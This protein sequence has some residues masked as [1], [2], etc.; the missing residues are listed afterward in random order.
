MQRHIRK[1]AALV[2]VLLSSTL[3]NGTRAFAHGDQPHLPFAPAMNPPAVSPPPETPAPDGTGPANAGPLPTSNPPRSIG[4]QPESITGAC[5]G[6]PTIDTVLLDEC[7]QH[8][9]TL[10]GNS[11]RVTVWYTKNVITATR[12]IDGTPTQ[13]FHWITSDNQAV[14]VGQWAEESWRRYFADSGHE[15]YIDGCSNN[16]NIQLEDGVGWSGIAYWA[17][18]GSCWIGIDAPM[19]RGGGGSGVVFHEMQHYLQY[20]YNAGCYGFLKPN[21]GG[22]SEFVEGYADLGEDS[23]NSTVDATGYAGGGYDPSTSFYD[24]DYNDRFNKYF[25]EQLGTIATPADPWHHM[26]ALYKHYERCDDQDTLYVLDSLVPSLSSG[27]LTEKQ[28]FLNFFAANWAKDW[29]NQAAQPELTY[30]D[31]DTGAYQQPPLTQDISMAGGSQSFPDTT[32]D[33]WAAKYYQ[34]TPQTGCSYLQM[35]VDGAP[36][37]DLG[38]NFMAAKTTAPTNVLRSAKIGEDFVRTFAAA[39]V[40][41]RMVAAVNSFNNNY[42]YTTRFTCVSPSINILEPRQVKFATVG[43]PESPIAFLSRW[44]VTDGTSTVRGLQ[45]SQF[46]FMAGGK[47]LNIVTGTF[48]EVGNQYWA[49]MVPPTQ[50][51]GTTFVDYTAC[52]DTLCDTEPS[53]LLYVNPGNTDIA[54]TFDASGSMLTE[55]TIGEGARITNAKK[56]GAVVADLLRPG[57]RI[58]VTDFSA[59]DNPV[60]CGASAAGNCALDL[61]TLLTRRDVT[62]ATV[63]AR[64]TETRNAINNYSARAWTPVSEGLADAKNKLLAVPSNLNPKHIFLLSDG[65]E[66]VARFYATLKAELIASGVVINTIAFGPEAPGNLMAQIA[67]DTGGVFRP[68][69]TSAGGAGLMQAQSASQSNV[70]AAVEAVDMPESVKA[71]LA[72]PFLPGQLGLANVYDYLDTEAQGASRIFNGNYI[73]V[74]AFDNVNSQRNLDVNMDPSVNQLRLVVAGK[75]P[76]DENSCASGISSDVR[77]VLVWTPGMDVDKDRGI[78]ISPRSQLTPADWVIVNNRFDDVLIVNNPEKGRWRFQT[79]YFPIDCTIG[80]AQTENK[81]TKTVSAE[82]SPSSIEATAN[83]APYAFSMNVSVQSTV[84]LEGR[85]LGLN[86]NQGNAGDAVSLIGTLVGR[87]GTVTPTAMLALVESAVGSVGVVMVDDGLHNDGSAGDNIF[88]GSYAQTSLGGSYSVRILTS[89]KDPTNPANALLREWNGGFWINGP[90]ADDQDK[91]GLPDDWERRCKLDT[92]RN[93]SREDPDRDGLT[94]AQELEAGTLPCRA[95]TDNGGERDGSEVKA[96]RNPLYAQ[97]DKVKPINHV[98]IRALNQMILIGWTKPLSYTDM[99][100]YVSTDLNQLGNGISMSQ[101]VPFTL[102]NVQNDVKYYLHLAGKN[103][104]A[105]GDYSEVVIVTPKADPD[106]PSGAIEINNGAETVIVKDVILN[107][108]STDT[109]LN[110]AAQGAN[111]HLTDQYSIRFNTVSAGVQM[112]ISNDSGMAGAVW[113]PLASTKPWTLACVAGQ[114]CTVY[115]QFKDAAGNESLIINDAVFFRATY[116]FLPLITK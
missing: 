59:F 25:I 26:D 7:Y 70:V 67:A 18:P 68:V 56:A 40:N 96:G 57:D 41:N 34:V 77:K 81:S 107:I 73:N 54:L 33:D 82:A 105:E 45:A 29:A 65:A 24:K 97:D 84:Q 8:N 112:R 63:S 42:S 86:N 71:G 48:Q 101:T 4:P 47:P 52:L 103:D 111:G 51:V 95:D 114:A 108:S 15:P 44:E 1:T 72:A 58:L 94:N 2:M 36:G 5:A 76:D 12:D 38:I 99:T 113:E 75:Q 16:L 106:P 46:S 88:G 83:G 110:G 31:D 35:E 115:A 28:L 37:A 98:T 85:I 13:L 11:R 78:P 90:S 64:I 9:F 50:T 102:T 23:V 100:L 43:S 17:G 74:P 62:T 22:D 92:T 61:R 3:A 91:D 80:L 69:A 19:V 30:W 39:G 27:R 79:Y 10:N 14:S 87:S 109:P 49:V 104:D 6:G 32:P 55:D 116:T 93:D 66:N 89:F 53:A 20:S 21:Y 60:G